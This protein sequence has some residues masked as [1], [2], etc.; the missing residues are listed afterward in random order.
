MPRL[1]IRSIERGSEALNSETMTLPFLP[2]TA[3]S[4][5][6]GPKKDEKTKTASGSKKGK[7]ASGYMKGPRIEARWD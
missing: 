5:A 4:P 2:V 7:K 6:A 3:F 1:T